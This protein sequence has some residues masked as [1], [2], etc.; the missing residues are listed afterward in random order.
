MD[1]FAVFRR[2][3]DSRLAANQLQPARIDFT[4]SNSPWTRSKKST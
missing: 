4:F 1:E 2:F 3:L